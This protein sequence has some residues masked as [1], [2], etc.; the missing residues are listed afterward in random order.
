MK[1]LEVGDSAQL[2]A[3]FLVYMDLYEGELE[4]I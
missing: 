1:E 4:K 2:H 3:A